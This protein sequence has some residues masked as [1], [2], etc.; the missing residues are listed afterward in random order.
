MR[1]GVGAALLLLGVAMIVAG[2]VRHPTVDVLEQR[3]RVEGLAV[4]VTAASVERAPAAAMGSGFADW[5]GKHGQQVAEFAAC[6]LDG[7]GLAQ[8]LIAGVSG[9][10]GILAAAGLAV[11]ALACLT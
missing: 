7:A 4:E 2:S 5:W 8:L 1:V 10:G 9:V 11:G 6:M 3:P